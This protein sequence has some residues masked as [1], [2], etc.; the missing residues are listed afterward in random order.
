MNKSKEEN[1]NC[2]N[3]FY[4]NIKFFNFEVKLLQLLFLIVI[5]LFLYTL[6][7]NK[8]TK[9]L[10]NFSSPLINENIEIFMLK[11]GYFF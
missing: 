5:L 3:I 9:K 6:L 8:S 10:S 7:E 4:R 1:K 2:L 11:G